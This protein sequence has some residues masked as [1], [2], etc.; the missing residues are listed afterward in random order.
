MLTPFSL[1]GRSWWC[2]LDDDNYPLLQPLL[3][4]LRPLSGAVRAPLPP[5]PRRNPP[6][7][8]VCSAACRLG[9]DVKV[10]RASLRT[11]CMENHQW[12]MLSGV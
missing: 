12:N 2:H 11:F 6:L 5:A 7:S 8:A 9:V 10:I 3:D 4:Y 1:E